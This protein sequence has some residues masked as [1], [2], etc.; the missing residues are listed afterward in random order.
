VFFYIENIR[1]LYTHILDNPSFNNND[2]LAFYENKNNGS[3]NSNGAK[4]LF[5][6]SSLSQLEGTGLE[7]G[8]AEIEKGKEKEEEEKIK[9]KEAQSRAEVLTLVGDLPS[10][11][12]APPENVLFVCKLNA[13]THDDDLEIIFGRFG[14]C[15]AKVVRDRDTGESLNYAFIVFENHE[16]AEEAYFKMDIALVDDK[17]IKVD[18]S[19][20][21][22]HSMNQQR[23]VRVGSDSYNFDDNRTKRRKVEVVKKEEESKS[24]DEDES[25]TSSY[26]SEEEERKRKKKK[27]KKKK[28]DHVKKKDKKKK[29]K[30]R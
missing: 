7:V 30:R 3:N 8:E 25:S 1:I 13:T 5:F 16:I 11:D 21:V 4:F 28:K 29:K 19:Q 22:R 27:K 10:P 20:S 9:M 23:R 15:N 14:R 17:R 2:F 24:E 6:P 18:F 26:D 12:V